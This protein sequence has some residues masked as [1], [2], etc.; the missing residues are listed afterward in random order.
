M[1]PVG[2]HLRLGV[3][4]A[5]SLVALLWL[6]YAVRGVLLPFAVGLF[7][8][9]LTEPLV[10]RMER[11]QVPRVVAL[12]VI[13]AG[14]GALI[15][16]GVI[17]L[18]P[19]LGTE[20]NRILGSV[21]ERA[22][23]LRDLAQRLL[24]A[25]N[26]RR[27]PALASAT[28]TGLAAELQ[29]WATQA[30]RYAVAAT[31]SLFSK[32]ALLLL[33][34]IIAFYASHDLPHWR[35]RVLALSPPTGR[36]ELREL[37]REVNA[38]VG[39]YLRGQLLVSSFVGLATWAGLAWL[40]LPYSLLIGILA[41]ITDIIPY[42]GPLIG[43]APAAVLGFSQSTPTGVYVLVLSFVIHQVEGGVLVPRIMGH[44]V[45]LHPI[46]VIFVLLAGG[47]LFGL[48]GMVLGVPVAAVVRVLL[49]HMARWL[50]GE[51]ATA[52]Q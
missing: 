43:L 27:L 2:R 49:K 29:R 14:I 47:Q 19:I 21:P 13:Y 22:A 17:Y 44:R 50:F 46:V 35:R 30:G 7:L 45:G 38:V 31:F 34:P 32:A 15:W 12:I 48:A 3:I 16:V 42:F 5:L 52:P 4:L 25:G 51:R 37:F 20:T 8:V 23:E 26:Q 24:S 1:S 6:L 36:R 40:G 18:W 33:A 28:L 9:Y 11:R 39:G 41:G 10:E